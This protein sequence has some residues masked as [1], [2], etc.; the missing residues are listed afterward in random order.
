MRKLFLLCA[1]LG[2]LPLSVWSAEST[3]AGERPGDSGVLTQGSLSAHTLPTVTVYGVADQP[4]VIPVTTRFGTQFNVVTEEQISR[5]NSLDFYDAL[6]NVPGVMFQKKNIIGGQTS[7]SLYIRGRGAS[8]PSPDLNILFDDVPRSGVLYGQALADGLPVY[9]LGGMEIYKYP[10]PSRFGSGYGMINFIPKYK[11]AEGSEFKIGME[12]GSHGT[13]A[14]N[15]SAGMKKGAFDIH[16][17]QSHLRTDGHVRH[18]AGD[19]TSFY[20]NAGY[21]ATKNWSLRL[22]AN[23]VDAST[24][25]PDNPLTKSKS[26]PRR[27]DTETSLVTLTLANEYEKASG[28]LKGY[29]NDTNFYLVNESTGGGIGNAISR[30]SNDLYGLRSRETFW[31]WKGSEIVAGFDLDRMDL[32]NRQKRHDGGLN[33]VWDFP[34]VTVFSPYLAV[35]Q[36]FGSDEDSTSLLRPACATTATASSTTRPRHR[37]V[38]CSGTRART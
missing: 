37:P 31:L 36:M 12:G 34:A 32:E 25:A 29:Y 30:Q 14:E 7:S 20:L 19:Q 38:W 22:L 28:Y 10:Q 33:R 26:Y 17:A 15:A 5:Q 24:E 11:V 23:H 18:S 16:A 8:H 21:Q 1:C 2:T 6:R 35:S 3:A 4:P 27:F 13:F 9:A